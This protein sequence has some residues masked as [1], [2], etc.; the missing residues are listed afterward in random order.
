MA[1]I[2]TNQMMD[3]LKGVPYPCSKQDLVQYAR[4]K[5]VDDKFVH[6]LESADRDE[7]NSPTDIQQALQ[8]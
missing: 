5:G 6:A 7:F 4:D 3:I 2:D 8:K 1:G